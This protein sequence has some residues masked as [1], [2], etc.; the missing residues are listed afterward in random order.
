MISEYTEQDHMLFADVS[1]MA[2]ELMYQHGLIAENWRFSWDRAKKRL[3]CCKY[4]EREISMSKLL[5]P[6]QTLAQI[7]NTILHEIAHA[8]VGHKHGHDHVWQAKAIE[9]GC[10]GKRCGTVDPESRPAYT[11]YSTCDD[12]GHRVGMH[13]A[14]GRVRSC[15]KCAPWGFSWNHVT[16]WEKDGQTAYVEDMPEKFQREY[17]LL[18]SHYA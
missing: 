17:N 8:L 5:T 1:K 11:W 7:Q 12:C 10:D 4:R 13:R 3:G 9:I 15:G 16:S 14:P 18:R 2:H 6:G